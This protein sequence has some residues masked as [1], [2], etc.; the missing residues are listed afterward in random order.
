MSG[1]Q[2]LPSELLC[3]GWV[4][5]VAQKTGL[6][7]RP[8]ALHWGFLAASVTFLALEEPNTSLPVKQHM[9]STDWLQAPGCRDYAVHLVHL[10]LTCGQ[11]QRWRHSGVE[12]EPGACGSDHPFIHSMCL[13]AGVSSHALQMTFVPFCFRLRIPYICQF[14]PF[15]QGKEN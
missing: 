14:F 10:N 2:G 11:T 12:P 4:P 13:T 9:C 7:R 1:W 6:D 15:F 3:P 8:G 5:T